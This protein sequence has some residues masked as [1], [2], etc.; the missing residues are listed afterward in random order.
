MRRNRKFSPLRASSTTTV[1][2]QGWKPL[3][4][5]MFCS[6]QLCADSV[7]GVKRKMEPASTVT[8]KSVWP[9]SDVGELPVVQNWSFV[10]PQFSGLPG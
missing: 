10:F 8:V 6:S 9:C 3:S 1:G 5:P 2:H 4:L 7:R